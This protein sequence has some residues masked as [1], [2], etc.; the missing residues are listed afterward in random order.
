MLKRILFLTLFVL[1]AAGPAFAATVFFDDMEGGPGTW[2]ADG[3]WHWA[4]DTD[5]CNEANSGVASWYYGNAACNFNEGRNFGNLTSEEIVLPAAGEIELSY[6]TYSGTEGFSFVFDRRRVQVSADGGPFV[7]VDE[8]TDSVWELREVDL[9]AFAGSTIRLRFFFDTVDSLFNNFRGWYVD[10]VEITGG[11]LAAFPAMVETDEDVSVALGIVPVDGEIDEVVIGDVPDGAFLSAGTDNGDGTWSL[12]GEDLDGLT[13]TP[14]PNSNVDFTLTIVITGV[15]FGDDVEQNGT[16][17]VSLDG[18]ADIPDLDAGSTFPFGLQIVAPVGIEA[19]LNDTDG[20]EVLLVT[21]DNV[22][23]DAF[24]SAG[25]NMGGGVWQLTSDQLGGLQIALPYRLRYYVKWDLGVTAEAREDDGDSTVLVDEV[26]VIYLEPFIGDDDT[27]GDDD[28]IV[29]VV[30]EAAVGDSG[31]G[32]T[33][34]GAVGFDP[35]FPLLAFGALGYLVR[36][37]NR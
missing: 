31:G 18:V 23:D 16:I 35:T 21:I 34:G 33:L 28:D 9:S 2:T 8:V 6:Y 10:D 12:L 26:K 1:L 14:P 25:V 24:L 27:A 19:A 22:P 3:L 30:V 15:L 17:V 29:T 13:I 11:G 5:P 20:S 32:C 7:T 4:D 36:R 37:R